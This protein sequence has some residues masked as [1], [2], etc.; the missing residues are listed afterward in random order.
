MKN[1]DKNDILIDKDKLII[2]E[3][4]VIKCKLYNLIRGNNIEK[5]FLHTLLLNRIHKSNKIILEGIYLFNIYVLYLLSINKHMEINSTTIRRCMRHLITNS[6]DSRNT[7]N[8]K[9]DEL[10]KHVKNTHFNFSV[11][12]REND[13]KSNEKS[14]MKPL[15]AT[16]DEYLINIK[17]NIQRNFKIY[18]RRYIM[19]K[20]EKYNKNMSENDIEFITYCVQQKIN[21]NIDYSYTV[22][23]R[24]ERYLELETEYKLNDFITIEQKILED[25]IN[26]NKNDKD[27][28]KIKIDITNELSSNCVKN[29]NIYYYLKYFSSMLNEISSGGNTKIEVK[30]FTILPHFK[31]KIRYIHFES[32]PL[33][34]IYNKWKNVN[35]NIKIFESNF[36]FYLNNMFTINEK[37]KKILRKYNTIRSI[38]TDGYCVSIGFEKMKKQLKKERKEN[39]KINKELLDLEDEYNKITTEKKNNELIFEAEN[40]KTTDMFLNKFNIGGVDPG[41]QIMLDITMESGLHISV[42]KNYYNELSHIKRNKEL[43][44]KEE[45]RLK[46]NEIYTKMSEGN[47]K[48]TQIIEYMKYVEMVRENWNELWKHSQSTIVKSLKFNSYVYK[49][50][51]IARITKETL[52]KLKN[53]GNVY[54]RHRKY[55]N[56]EKYN[57]DNKKPILLCMGKGNGSITI[58][59]TKNSSPKGPIKKIV[60]ELSKRC[61]VILTPEQNTS[62]LCSKCDN[63]LKEVNV[64]KIPKKDKDDVKLIS[65][66]NKKSNIRNKK[67]EINKLKMEIKNKCK[68]KTE[69][70]IKKQKIIIIKDDK[71]AIKIKKEEIKNKEKGIKKE[72][73]EVKETKYYGPS[74]RLHLCVNKHENLEGCILWERNM[75]ASKNMMKMMR[76]ITIRKTKGNFNKI[77]KP[78]GDENLEI[79]VSKLRNKSILNNLDRLLDIVKTDRSNESCK[80]IIRTL[81][82]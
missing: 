28:D 82:L 27:N 41:N 6:N 56:E 66:K 3:V 73:K 14:F 37:Y 43:L 38:S 16:A 58:T 55:F 59:N 20:L 72:E 80:G 32:R 64:F 75:N 25:N 77:K 48:T 69:K 23:E 76:N 40:I 42:H 63:Q 21:G 70:N 78:A 8:D 2:D 5:R 39:V 12:G 54:P 79:K 44:D 51:A 10:I 17:V 22:K 36:K 13:F 4:R 11:E 7:G 9:E 30:R 15:E 71:K 26:Q 57:E 81:G 60:K 67:N 49:D 34:G 33:C 52:L 74:Y 50:K 29:N 19:N 47:T 18:Q 35:I 24:K 46:I 1:L 61:V 62:Q 31:P 65:V 45:K 53:K 68:I